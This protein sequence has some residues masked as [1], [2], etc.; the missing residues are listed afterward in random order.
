VESFGTSRRFSGS[1]IMKLAGGRRHTALIAA[2]SAA[3]AS[4][5]LL[6]A[7]SALA[8]RG[9]VFK[10]TFGMPCTVEPCA[11]GTLKEPS[12]VAVNEASGDIY[13]LDQGNDRIK[14]F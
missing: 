2:L 7:S 3:V 14:N 4:L 8:A 5:I 13:V 6:T 10:E 11:P 1:R 12:A 9:H